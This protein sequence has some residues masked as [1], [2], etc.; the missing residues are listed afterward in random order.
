MLL[1]TAAAISHP[2]NSAQGS[3]FSTSSPVL[4]LAFF[5]PYIGIIVIADG[6]LTAVLICISLEISHGEHASFR[7]FSGHLC[8][9][10]GEMS[11]PEFG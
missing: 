7:V 1:S 6:Y 5:C 4:V 8:I 10:C 9:F 3:S 11:V 2:G